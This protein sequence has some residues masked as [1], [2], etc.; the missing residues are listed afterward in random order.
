M[1]QFNQPIISIQQLTPLLSHGYND[2]APL[3]MKEE[4]W[5]RIESVSLMNEGIRILASV[6]DRNRL[7]SSGFKCE[8]I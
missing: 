8:S 4:L 3:E 5:L 2:K 7:Q 6:N 1:G